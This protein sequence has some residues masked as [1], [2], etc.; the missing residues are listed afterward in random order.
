MVLELALTNLPLL[1]ILV[2]AG[3]VIAEAFAPGAHFFVVGVALLAAGLVGFLGAFLLPGPIN[4]LL[5]AI[6][7]LLS[8]LATLWAYRQLDVM[9]GPGK[10][11]TSDSSSLRGSTGRVTERVTPTKGE[12]KLSDGGFNPYYKARSMDGE[13][14]EEEE[15]I[16]V[17][18]GG[19][20]V[21]TVESVSK[22]GND[23]DRELE[24]EREREAETETS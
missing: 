12:I 23:I 10:G 1:L 3:L 13:I 15:V 17:D 2:G 11:K 18:P 14:S 20:N 5:M 6:V 8:S 16:V 9:G 4:L 7:V 19:G 21:V 24:R 22:I